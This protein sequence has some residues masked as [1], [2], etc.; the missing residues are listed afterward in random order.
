[1]SGMKGHLGILMGMA[2]IGQSMMHGVS[3]NHGNVNPAARN[4]NK[5]KTVSRNHKLRQKKGR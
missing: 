2:V 5:N 3:K 1:M 4:M